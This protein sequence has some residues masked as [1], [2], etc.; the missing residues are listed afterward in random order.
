MVVSKKYS[1][2]I[3]ISKKKYCNVATRIV[4]AVFA[5]TKLLVIFFFTI[6]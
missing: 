2:R 3:K 1:F 4:I 6:S 5:L